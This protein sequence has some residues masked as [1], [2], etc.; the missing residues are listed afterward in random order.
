MLAEIWLLVTFYLSNFLPEPLTSVF[1][2]IE[3]C[4]AADFSLVGEGSGREWEIET[5]FFIHDVMAFSRSLPPLVSQIN[6]QTH[7]IPSPSRVVPYKN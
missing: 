2:T 3:L 6:L 4:Q 1:Y 7:K 5:L